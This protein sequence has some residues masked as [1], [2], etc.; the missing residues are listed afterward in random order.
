MSSFHRD[1]I[2]ELHELEDHLCNECGAARAATAPRP[3]AAALRILLVGDSHTHGAFGAELE[4]LLETTGAKVHRAAKIGSAVRY[5]WPRLPALLRDHQ[6]DLVIVALGAN[7]R[8]YPS[9]KGTAAQ[10]HKTIGLIA[11]ERPAARIIWIGPPRERADTEARLQEFNQ[12]IKRGVGG[13]AVFID[14]SPHTPRYVGRD[15]V[16]YASAPARAWAAGVFGELA[17]SLSHEAELEHAIGE[18]DELAAEELEAL[19]ELE[20]PEAPRADES[21]EANAAHDGSDPESY[22]DLESYEDPESYGDPESYEDPEDG[23]GELEDEL[24][25]WGFD[26]A[27]TPRVIGAFGQGER[28]RNKLTSL[29]FD[30]QGHAPPGH[31]ITKAEPQLV[32]QWLR[33]RDDIVDPALNRM[34]NTSPPPPSP[35][36]PVISPLALV[37]RFGLR[38]GGKRRRPVYGVVVHTT[39]GGLAAKANRGGGGWTGPCNTPLDCALAIYAKND[40]FPHYVIDLH[41]LIVCVTSEDHLA[42]HAGAGGPARQW[43]RDHGPPAW[44]NKVWAGVAKSPFD[45]PP[46]SHS[47]NDQY[48]GVELVQ[49]KD[50][51]YTDAQYRSLA[52]LILDLEQR[53]HLTLSR[54]PSRPLL[55]HEDVNPAPYQDGK[56]GGRSLNDLSA[57]WDPGASRGWFSWDKL[58][59]LMRGGAVPAASPP[60]AA[61]PRPPVVPSSAPTPAHRPAP[62]QAP[63]GV[64]PPSD[65]GAYRSFRLTNYYVL[66][67][68]DRPTGSVVVPI[69]DKHGKQ[70]AEGSPGFFAGAALEGTGRLIDGRLINV[71]G[72]R[73]RVDPDLYAPV[74][75]YHKKHLAKRPPGYSGLHVAGDRVVA[76]SAFHVIDP[77]K[78]GEGYGVLHGMPLVPFRTLAADIGAMKRS[79]PAYRGKGGLVPLRTRVFI[80]EFVGVKLPGGDVH[81]GW[82]VVGDTGG[83]INGAH[84]D[85]FTGTRALA[86][87]VK[88]PSVGTVWFPGIE[89]RIARGYSYGL[90]DK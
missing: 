16:H 71:S 45:L 34:L 40:G 62:T 42:W 67:Q 70:I 50:G 73:V 4:R 47:V 32:K 72:D 17:A 54:P 36:G 22:V 2:P 7:M 13:G 6:P 48:I 81:D 80:K 25:P 66:D 10:F 30:A 49:G 23:A 39:G 77:A 26:L 83:A 53:H 20:D 41:G 57:G 58:W 14:S 61:P 56:V 82:F 74:W 38:I 86:R 88:L 11:R 68:A 87:Q 89:T 37:S 64:T 12:R 63:A 43:L 65:P 19:R 35:S 78:L 9:A 69:Y 5:W 76:A 29:I 3:A 85:V 79:E 27:W 52:A 84:F 59:S 1:L 33:I 15:G 44:W 28:D 24:P 51:S 31:V 55:G 46:G 8:D 21:D 75:E 18:S 60:A 90:H